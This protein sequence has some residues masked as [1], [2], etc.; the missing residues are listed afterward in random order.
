MVACD[1]IPLSRQH[2]PGHDRRC[3]R[4]SGKW[5]PNTNC[6]DSTESR[7]S[8]DFI[9]LDHAYDLDIAVDKLVQGRHPQSSLRQ[10]HQGQIH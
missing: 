5:Q 4:V 8:N 10:R 2:V 6:L 9:F 3:R 7:R 1:T